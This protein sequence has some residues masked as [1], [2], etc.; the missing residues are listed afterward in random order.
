MWGLSAWRSV[1]EIQILPSASSA[2]VLWKVQGATAAAR[3]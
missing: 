2:L 1:P 3:S